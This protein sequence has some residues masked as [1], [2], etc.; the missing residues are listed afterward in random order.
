MDDRKTGDRSQSYTWFLNQLDLESLLIR[1]DIH[2]DKLRWAEF[3]VKLSQVDKKTP[4]VIT[5]ARYNVDGGKTAVV[6]FSRTYDA[7]C[8]KAYSRALKWLH[9]ELGT[10]QTAPRRLP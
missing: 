1:V 3:G 7:A 6:E 2:S 10:G 5:E 4:W 9:T 8:R